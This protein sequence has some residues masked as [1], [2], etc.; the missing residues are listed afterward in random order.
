MLETFKILIDYLKNPKLEK[1]TNKSLRYR[2]LILY[3]LFIFC[4]FTGILLSF[5]F[6]FLE[7]LG[8]LDMNSHKLESAFK[9]L[10]S[11]KII[12][13]G[14]IVAPVIEELIFR[15][16]LVLFTSKKSFKIIFGF[17]HLSNYE[18]TPKILLI[19]PILVLPQIILG[20]YLGFIRIRFGLQW[21]IL[22]HACYNGFLMLISF[23]GK[24]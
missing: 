11:Y 4:L 3:R 22:L 8:L 5:L 19:S 10:G 9:K 24:N 23:T 16:P 21:S 6:G 14:T 13:L 2:F 7:Q 17:V 12:L 15:A 18:I 1:D 20:A